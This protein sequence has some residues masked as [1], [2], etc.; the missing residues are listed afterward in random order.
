M[1]GIYG[2]RVLPLTY[3]TPSPRSGLSSECTSATQGCA[4]REVCVC[5]QNSSNGVRREGE[6]GL[7]TEFLLRF[8]KTQDSEESKN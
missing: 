4:G 1:Q 3:R 7:K 2:I 5:A 6:T 8:I